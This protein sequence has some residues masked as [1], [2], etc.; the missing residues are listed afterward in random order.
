MQKDS[1]VSKP[2]SLVLPINF[3]EKVSSFNTYLFFS[4]YTAD[5]IR[6]WIAVKIHLVHNPLQ[7]VTHLVAI[8]ANC[9]Q[10]SKAFT[11]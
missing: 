8:H 10:S 3:C 1:I 4:S 2:N 6:K 9:N 7:R 11:R 5:E